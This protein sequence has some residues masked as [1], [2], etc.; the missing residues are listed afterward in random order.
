R[1][2]RNVFTARGERARKIQKAF[3]RYHDPENWPLLRQALR[4]MG[5]SDLIGNGRNYLIPATQPTKLDPRVS[6]AEQK[7]KAL[8]KQL[9]FGVESSARKRSERAN[10]PAR[11]RAGKK[12]GW[13][14]SRPRQGRQ[15]YRFLNPSS[16]L[17]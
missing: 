5:R 16:E 1:A 13:A 4:D 14:R 6:G 12:Q 7:Y 3:L 11:M 17:A 15:K 10:M 9:L 2:D 8:V